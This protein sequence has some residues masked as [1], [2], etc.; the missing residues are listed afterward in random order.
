MPRKKP[1]ETTPHPVSTGPYSLTQVDIDSITDVE[2]AF[3]T[4]K[5]LPAEEEI[6]EAFRGA[7]RADYDS[8]VYVKLVDALFCGSKVPEGAL[9]FN[10]GFD[11]SPEGTKKLYRFTMAHLRSF[12]PNHQ[13]KISGIA[14]MLSLIVTITPEN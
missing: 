13:H 10:E 3:A 7:Y 4:T 1:E 14:Y 6:P 2:V 11:S 12:E 5:C 8:N 9:T